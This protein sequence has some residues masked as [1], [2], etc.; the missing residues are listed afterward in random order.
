M[1]FFTTLLFAFMGGILPA[2]LWLYFW[3]KEDEHPEP[4]GL[5]VLSFF[6]GMLAVPVALVSQWVI[7]FLFLRGGDIE[8]M[9]H[10]SYPA[11]ISVLVIWA[12]IEEVLKY[13]AANNAGLTKKE[14]DEPVDVMIYLITAA[15][16]FAALEN[17][18]FI[19]VP[20]LTGDITTALITGNLR[21][22]GATLLHVA[23][24]ALIGVFAA[25]SYYKSKEIK[26]HYLFTG[27]FL[28]V[29]LHTIFNSFIIRS[30]QFTLVGFATVWIVIVLIIIL[31]ERIKKI[32]KR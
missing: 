3:L 30:E 13:V 12:T 1:D 16:G 10:T 17:T 26:K 32:Y 25:F 23:S 19:F 14:N 7:N 6:Y 20:I 21:F 2:L 4:K 24:S 5:I 8:L 15:L 27:F 11:A 22:I 9:F 18:L 31:F 29:A 28:S